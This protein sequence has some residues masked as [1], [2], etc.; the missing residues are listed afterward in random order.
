MKETKD[1]WSFILWNE[2]FGFSTLI[3]LTWLAEL[4]RI[5]H[6]L[7]G[8]PFT[9]DWKRAILRTVV[10][11][12]IWLW[13]NQVTKRLLKRLHYLEEFIRMCGWCKRV[14]Y[15]GE[16]LSTEKYL[17]SKYDM[18]TTH[19]VCP[20]CLKGQKEEI[21]RANSPMASSQPAP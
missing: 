4:F 5:P 6:Y 21:Q 10:I 16:W 1:K 9:T 13:V 20:D 3:V 2:A 7:F 11:L 17:N 12:C 18:H 8:E 14:C 15:Q 19:G